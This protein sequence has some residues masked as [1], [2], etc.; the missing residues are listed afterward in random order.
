MKMETRVFSRQGRQWPMESD[1]FVVPMSTICSHN[2]DE[3]AKGKWNILTV[4]IN[5]K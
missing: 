1:V 5:W 2:E 3:S 4:E